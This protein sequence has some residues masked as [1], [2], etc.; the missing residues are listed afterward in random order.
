MKFLIFIT[1]LAT[2]NK[3]LQVQSVKLDGSK[4]IGEIVQWHWYQVSGPSTIIFDNPDSAVVN[5]TT[6]HPYLGT[7][8]IG[9]S[10]KDASGNATTG[11]ATIN[12]TK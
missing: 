9:L 6:D 12:V 8:V 11:T 3:T 2:C 4:S 7:Y 1:L 10:V 5:V